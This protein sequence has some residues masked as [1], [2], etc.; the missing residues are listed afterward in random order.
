MDQIFEGYSTTR[1]NKEI[2]SHENGD[3]SSMD[4]QYPIV[5]TSMGETAIM[6]GAVLFVDDDRHILRTVKKHITSAGFTFINTSRSDVALNLIEKE[7]ISVIVSGEHVPGMKGVELLSK[8]RDISPAIVNILMVSYANLPAAFDAIYNEDV[9]RFVVKPLSDKSLVQIMHDAL[10]RHQQ[11]CTLKKIDAPTLLSIAQ[12]IEIKD[13]YTKGH[14]ERVARYALMIAEAMN[15]PD[16]MKKFIEYGSWLHDCGKINIP[17]SILNQNGILKKEEYQTI[18]THPL[19]G[20]D[21]VKYA[22]LPDEI[23][24]IVLYHHERY[25]GNGYPFGLK[26]AR[27]PVEAHIVSIADVFDALTTDR[28]YRKKYTFEKAIKLLAQMK[29]SILSPEITDIFLYYCLR[30][31]LK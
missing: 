19:W 12:E 10:H 18:K 14:C 25:D 30:D 29:G 3:V 21:I 8:A 2:T 22:Q 16:D 31:T 26:G 17:K 27:I 4:G 5:I 1:K 23:I 6:P 9:Y 11:I 7:D 13:E 24:N 20:A 28:P 15:L